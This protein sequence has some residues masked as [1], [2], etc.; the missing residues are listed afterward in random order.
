ML[1]ASFP[2]AFLAGGRGFGVHLAAVLQHGPVAKTE[3]NRVKS[4]T[5]VSTSIRLQL[6][7]TNCVLLS[8]KRFSWAQFQD[9][10]TLS[11]AS[12]SEL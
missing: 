2:P 9:R 6:L 10:V 3:Q 11:S 8:F 4:F 1:N 12:T 5:N 7:L